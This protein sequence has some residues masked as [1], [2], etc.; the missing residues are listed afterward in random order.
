MVDFCI[1]RRV[2]DSYAATAAALLNPLS[3]NTYYNSESDCHDQLSAQPNNQ[4]YHHSAVSEQLRRDGILAQ[5][6]SSGYSMA[7][8]QAPHYLA[9]GGPTT[10]TQ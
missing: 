5:S 9:E 3:S 6:H 10:S 2:A 4:T 1:W 8:S 7:E